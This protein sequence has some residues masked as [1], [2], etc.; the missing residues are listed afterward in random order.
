MHCP[1]DFES[2]N[3]NAWLVATI[4]KSNLQ[5]NTNASLILNEM[6]ISNNQMP[7][8]HLCHQIKAAVLQSKLHKYKHIDSAH[9]QRQINYKFQGDT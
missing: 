6:K 7:G 1:K 9:I 8:Q 2:N 3:E 5:F 4:Q